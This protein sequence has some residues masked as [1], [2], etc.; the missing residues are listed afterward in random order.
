MIKKGELVYVPAET[1]LV[2]FNKEV[3]N[4]DIPLD[5]TYI[6]PSPLKVNK[7]ERPMYLLLVESGLIEEKY[8]KVWYAGEDWCVRHK[9]VIFS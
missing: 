7:L 5:K 8:I 6:G 1:T 9:D 3:E 2:K 4:I